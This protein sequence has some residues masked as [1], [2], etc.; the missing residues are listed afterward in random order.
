MHWHGILG[1]SVLAACRVARTWTPADFSCEHFNAP[2]GRYWQLTQDDDEPSFCTWELFDRF[3]DGPHECLGQVFPLR[4]GETIRA[5]GA[6][7]DASATIIFEDDDIRDA[8]RY[9]IARVLADESR[10]GK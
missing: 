4:D 3:Y 7:H 8:A 2:T 10:G 6:Y 5:W 1:A 9:L